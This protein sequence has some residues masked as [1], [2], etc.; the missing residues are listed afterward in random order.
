VAATTGRRLD[1][2]RLPRWLA[3]GYSRAGRRW[4]AA[5]ILA[6]AAIRQRSQEYARATAGE[7]ARSVGFRRRDTSQYALAPAW[8]GGP[9]GDDLSLGDVAVLAEGQRH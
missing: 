5:T 1:G 2:S 8:A 7:L 9:A 4:R 6:S 3:D